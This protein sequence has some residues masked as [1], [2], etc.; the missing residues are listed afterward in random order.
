MILSIEPKMVSAHISKG[1]TL[2]NLGKYNDAVPVYN[3]VFG[4]LS[5]QNKGIKR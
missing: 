5:G 1:G 2:L 4:M 3:K